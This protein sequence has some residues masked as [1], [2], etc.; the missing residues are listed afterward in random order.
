MLDKAND[1]VEASKGKGEKKFQEEKDT[2]ERRHQIEFKQLK[3]QLQIENEEWKDLQ[4]KKMTEEKRSQLKALKEDMVKEKNKKIEEVIDRLGDETH[5]THKKLQ[6]QFSKKEREIEAKCQEEI[7]ELKSDIILMKEKQEKEKQQKDMLDEN[8]KVLSNRLHTMEKDLTEKKIT[9]N[10]LSTE[11]EDLTNKLSKIYKE[12]ETS[13]FEMDSLN[14]KRLGEKDKEIRVLRETIDEV[15]Q[16][17]DH[18]VSKVREQHKD[19]INNLE[20]KVKAA[21]GKKQE[22]INQLLEEVRTKELQVIAYKKQLEEQR[23][24]LLKSH[25]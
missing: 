15:E 21:L 10:S 22:D 23:H 14:H 13:R 3:E 4:L 19:Q 6:V 25:I 24:E 9:I 5:D 1:Q 17:H 8:I 20:I 2:L 7:Q 11:K 12:E 16:K 18:D